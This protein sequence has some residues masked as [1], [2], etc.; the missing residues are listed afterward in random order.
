MTLLLLLLR[1]GA[2]APDDSMNLEASAPI[3]LRREAEAPI[4]GLII[5]AL[6]TLR[7]GAIVRCLLGVN[8]DLFE[9]NGESEARRDIAR[10][11]ALIIP[12]SGELPSGLP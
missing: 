5:S 1:L 2:L 9:G 12:L 11:I 10:R 3:G 4:G 6:F 7:V 8:D